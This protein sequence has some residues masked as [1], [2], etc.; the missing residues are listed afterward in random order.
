MEGRA[1]LPDS[2]AWLRRSGL[3]G[4]WAGAPWAGSSAWPPRAGRGGPS[5]RARVMGGG[6]AR[7]FQ[8]GRGFSFPLTPGGAMISRS[9]LLPAPRRASPLPLRRRCGSQA[10]AETPAAHRLRS[11]L[12]ESAVDTAPLTLQRGVRVPLGL[13]AVSDGFPRRGWGRSCGSGE[14]L[15]RVGSFSI[16]LPQPPSTNPA[17]R[18]GC[19]HSLSG[20]CVSPERLGRALGAKE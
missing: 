1:G 15:P 5:E 8:R 4:G 17:P 2:P 7:R 9:V 16:T 3:R 6:Q 11:G 10:P 14:I 18:K 13:S 12:S 20:D 19:G